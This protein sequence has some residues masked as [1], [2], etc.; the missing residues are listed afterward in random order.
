LGT[1][2]NQAV[3]NFKNKSAQ[4]SSNDDDQETSD[5][6]DESSEDEDNDHDLSEQSSEEL[7]V[8]DLLSTIAAWQHVQAP[9]H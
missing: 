6:E 1:T 5:G 3:I 7:A 8:G 2:A 4:A 9:N